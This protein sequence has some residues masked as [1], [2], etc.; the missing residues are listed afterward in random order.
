MVGVMVMAMVMVP[1]AT[2]VVGH[3]AG[4]YSVDECCREYLGFFSSGHSR[5]EASSHEKQQSPE[6]S[7]KN[8]NR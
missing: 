6:I 3:A 1:R 5:I 7:G 2:V 4:A 8:I